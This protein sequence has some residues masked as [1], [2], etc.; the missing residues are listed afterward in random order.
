M[1]GCGVMSWQPPSG[2]L[3]GVGVCVQECGGLRG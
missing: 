1:V 2:P 3:Q